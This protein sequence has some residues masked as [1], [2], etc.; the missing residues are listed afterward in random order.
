MT[1]HKHGAHGRKGRIAKKVAVG[2]AIGLG[3]AIVAVPVLVVG[4]IAIP[5]MMIGGSIIASTRNREA[6]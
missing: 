1:N 4:G 5:I 2:A 6:Q 3:I